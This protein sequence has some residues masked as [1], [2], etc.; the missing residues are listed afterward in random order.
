MHDADA[1]NVVG[2]DEVGNF[3]ALRTERAP[4]ILVATAA[5]RVVVAAAAARSTSLPTPTAAAAIATGIGHVGR[6]ARGIGGTRH[7]RCG[8]FRSV[9]AERINFPLRV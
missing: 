9:R 8:I 2:L 3:A 5:I 6:G 7:L 1:G 4:M